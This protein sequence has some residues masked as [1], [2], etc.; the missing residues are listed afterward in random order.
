MSVLRELTAAF[1]HSGRIESIWLRPARRAPMQAVERTEAIAGRGLAGDHR[2][3]RASSS[4]DGSPRQVTLIQAEHLPV[5]AALLRQP[6]VSP[7][8]LRRNL[9]VSGINLL[10]ARSL[11]RDQPLILRIGAEVVLQL[12]GPCEP[13]SRMEENLGTGGYNAMR[14]HGGVNARVLVGGRIA[15]HDTVACEPAMNRRG[16]PRPMDQAV[17]PLLAEAGPAHTS[18]GC[19]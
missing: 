7:A 1:T 13:C 2:A 16:S 3:A 19:D 12:A 8:A 15:R 6:E 18:P 4:A 17:N 9:V 11:F 10:A 14:G 5:I